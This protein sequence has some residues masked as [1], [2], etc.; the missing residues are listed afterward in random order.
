MSF[1]KQA[2]PSIGNA[3]TDVS[4]VKTRNRHAP[5][6]VTPELDQKSRDTL[7]SAFTV[8]TTVT[9]LQNQ[10]AAVAFRKA[11][12]DIGERFTPEFEVTLTESQEAEWQ[13]IS[14]LPTN[15]TAEIQKWCSRMSKFLVENK[16]RV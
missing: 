6:F 5:N 4:I 13:Y 16:R 7:N 12:R 3:V 2:A 8:V 15:N 11:V 1:H 10:E 9:A 14:S